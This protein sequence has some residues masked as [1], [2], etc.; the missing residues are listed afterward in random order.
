MALLLYGI[1]ITII[2]I[3]NIIISSSI[4]IINQQHRVRPVAYSSLVME[5]SMWIPLEENKD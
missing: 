5:K 4:S 1:F 2:I 3:I